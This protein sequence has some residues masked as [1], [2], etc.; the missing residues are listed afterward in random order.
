[1]AAIFK[2]M[3]LSASRLQEQRAIQRLNRVVSSTVDTTAFWG[4]RTHGP[5]TSADLVS[6]SRSFELPRPNVPNE[7]HA[8]ETGV[9]P[10][11]LM[12][13]LLPGKAVR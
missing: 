10:T 7:P 6:K 11:R 1:M 8:L 5:M 3:T 2:A 4:G 12:P 13:V 9:F